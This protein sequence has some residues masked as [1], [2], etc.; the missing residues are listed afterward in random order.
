MPTV[1]RFFHACHNFSSDPTRLQKEGLK[2]YDSLLAIARQTNIGH[3]LL[4]CDVTLFPTPMLNL[5][6][7][8]GKLHSWLK[9]Q[10]QSDV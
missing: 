5:R 7:L 1:H 9:F 2:Q 10:L 3:S 6:G 4:P 8:V